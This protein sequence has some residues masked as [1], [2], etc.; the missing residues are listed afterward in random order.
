MKK[1]FT[2]L[3]IAALLSP[4]FA[5]AN[6]LDSLIFGDPTRC[7]YPPTDNSFCSCFMT[8]SVYYCLACGHG[9]AC[10]ESNIRKNMKHVPAGGEQGFCDQNNKCKKIPDYAKAECPADIA[11]YRDFC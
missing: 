9:A 11:Y 10:N 8:A 3:A 1:T 6:P 7:A 2:S 5:L 4:L